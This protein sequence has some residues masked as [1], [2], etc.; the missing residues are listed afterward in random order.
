MLDTAGVAEDLHLDSTV[1][2]AQ[3][4]AIDRAVAPVSVIEGSQ[5]ETALSLRPQIS[6]QRKKTEARCALQRVLV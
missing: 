3:G 4:E 1:L 6:R 2:G 5:A